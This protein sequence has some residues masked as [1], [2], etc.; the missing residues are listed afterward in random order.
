MVTEIPSLSWP[1][2]KIHLCRC[3][4]DAERTA[5][6]TESVPQYTETRKGIFPDMGEFI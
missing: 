5:E 3:Q 1:D 2:F 6:F 4:H